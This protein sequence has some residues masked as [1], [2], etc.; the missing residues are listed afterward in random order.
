MVLP[1]KQIVVEQLC[2][3]RW[4]VDEWIEVAPSSLEEEN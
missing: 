4:N 1:K 3:T 2:E